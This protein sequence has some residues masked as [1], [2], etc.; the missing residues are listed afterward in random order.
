MHVQRI[1][2]ITMT[3][4]NHA[5]INGT[6]FLKKKFSL[7]N[8]TKNKINC[9]YLLFLPLHSIVLHVHSFNLFTD[10]TKGAH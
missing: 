10:P 6:K 2:L 3:T 7:N 5:F 9:H 1:N 4:I 8:K